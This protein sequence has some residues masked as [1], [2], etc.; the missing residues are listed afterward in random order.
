MGWL[1]RTQDWERVSEEQANKIKDLCGL[2]DENTYSYE[3]KDAD[4]KDQKLFEE[5]STRDFIKDPL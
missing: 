5:C 2:D 4:I 3:D 1:G